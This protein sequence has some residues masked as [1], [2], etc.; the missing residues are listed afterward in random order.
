M[1]DWFDK[2]Y[3]IYCLF[4]SKLHVR[5][6]LFKP[7]V[8]KS[9]GASAHQPLINSTIKDTFS[10]IINQWALKCVFQLI[11]AMTY[12]DRIG[13]WKIDIIQFYWVNDDVTCLKLVRVRS[14]L[15]VHRGNTY[16]HCWNDV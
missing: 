6:V 4:L 1:N 12:D 16:I 10:R 14:S 13:E 3:V 9:G 5:N 2:I 7:I 8:W 11:A 15:I